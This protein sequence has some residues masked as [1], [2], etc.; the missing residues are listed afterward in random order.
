MPYILWKVYNCVLDSIILLEEGLTHF[1]CSQVRNFTTETNFFSVSD[2]P[3]FW[4]NGY[5]FLLVAILAQVSL[6]DSQTQF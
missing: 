6:S 2:W 3:S 4:A 5:L 1:M